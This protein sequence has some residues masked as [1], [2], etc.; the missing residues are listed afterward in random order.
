MSK[1]FFID[2]SRCTACRGCQLACK[3][4]NDLPANQT[5][6]YGWGSHQNPP[7]LNPNNYK[8][9]RFNEH[10]DKDGVVHWNFFPD[11]CRHCV[12]PPCKDVADSIMEGIVV[13]DMDTGAVL[14]TDLSKMLSR[15][16]FESIRE[17]CPYDIPRR[18]EGSGM[19]SKCTMCFERLQNGM[20]PA[21]VKVCPTGTMNFGEREDM[22][23][24][25]NKRLAA[26]RKTNPGASL[27]DP[28]DVNVIY[29]IMDKPEYYATNTRDSLAP[30]MDR[31]R[32]LADL[33]RPFKAMLGDIEKLS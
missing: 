7:D 18:D 2:T 22:L 17:G 4:W 16:D 10:L 3:E 23:A 31:K 9:V 21:C 5:K 6:Q 29:L 32:F 13:Q 25:A 24:L 28:E 1:S 19:M 27:I 30:G 15:E 33:A 11:Q 14:F 26:A 8:L 20:V 12:N